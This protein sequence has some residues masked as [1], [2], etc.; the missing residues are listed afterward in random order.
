[1]FNKSASERRS[2]RFINSRTT[3]LSQQAGASMVEATI[4]LLFLIAGIIFTSVDLSMAAYQ[5]LTS[6]YVIASTAR[7][8]SLGQVLEDPQNPGSY[9][10]REASIVYRLRERAGAFGL[11]LSTATI[12][13]CPALINCPS[14]TQDAG[15]PNETIQISVNYPI[16]FFFKSLTYNRRSDVFV[17]NEPFA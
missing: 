1:M 5:A 13:M 11:D 3:S 17:R 14:G 16:H 4:G 7:W 12:E 10:S 8:G 2:T 15:G 6:Q 9:F